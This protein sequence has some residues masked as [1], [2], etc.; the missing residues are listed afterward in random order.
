MSLKTVFIVISGPA[1]F[2]GCV[3]IVKSLLV[4]KGFTT[5]VITP[6][7]PRLKETIMALSH[8]S[9]TQLDQC[10]L[11][12]VQGPGHIVLDP[13]YFQTL[14]DR[15]ATREGVFLGGAQKVLYLPELEKDHEYLDQ[16]L[17]SPQ[18]ETHADATCLN[19]T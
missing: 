15:I 19:R 4:K 10:R 1:R 18:E 9:D 6:E 12:K 13:K 7:D 11:I 8:W 16:L 3:P 14:C 5:E 2:F 17:T